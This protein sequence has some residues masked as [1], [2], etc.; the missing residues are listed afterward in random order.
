MGGL[1]DRFRNRRLSEAEALAFAERAR[2]LRYEFPEQAPI[3]A[4]TLLS[5]RRPEDQANDLWTTFNR[6]QEQLI[7]GV[8]PESSVLPCFGIF[9]P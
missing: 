8:A 4:A 6:V 2:L 1:I 7:R 5:A 9:D 3:G